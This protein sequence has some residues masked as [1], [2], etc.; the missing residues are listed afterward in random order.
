MAKFKAGSSAEPASSLRAPA[1]EAMLRV[2]SGVLSAAQ[3]SSSSA[4][5]EAATAQ[6]QRRRQTLV[7]SSFMADYTRVEVGGVNIASLAPVNFQKH[8]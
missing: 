3:M 6:V 8:D 4:Q 1:A 7:R 5:A 2:C